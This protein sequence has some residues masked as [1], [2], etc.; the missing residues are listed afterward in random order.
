MFMGEWAVHTSLPQEL[1]DVQFREKVMLISLAIAAVTFGIFPSILFNSIES[2][3]NHIV[4]F[5]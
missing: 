1:Q 2:T 5:F 4:N 3:V